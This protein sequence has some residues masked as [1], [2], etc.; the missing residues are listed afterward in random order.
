MTVWITA[1]E[2]SRSYRVVV[3]GHVS[4]GHG[5]L[6]VCYRHTE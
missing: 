4:T 6:D 5:S 1:H 3:Y 2:H